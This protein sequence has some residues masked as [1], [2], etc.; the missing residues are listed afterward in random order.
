MLLVSTLKA[1]LSYLGPHHLTKKKMSAELNKSVIPLRRV[2]RVQ[3]GVLGPEEVVSLNM[4][5]LTTVFPD[6]GRVDLKKIL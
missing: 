2:K 5:D 4:D 3:F 1:E 6:K